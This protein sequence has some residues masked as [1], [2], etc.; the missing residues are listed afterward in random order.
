MQHVHRPKFTHVRFPEL[1][2]SAWKSSRNTLAL[3]RVYKSL[4]IENDPY[5]LSLR[6]ALERPQ[7]DDATRNRTSQRLSKALDKKDTFVHKG[8]R[9]FLRCAKD[10]CRDLG[11]WAADWYI[12]SVVHRALKGDAEIIHQ[13]F[14]DRKEPEK[15]Y[16]IEVLK[17]IEATSPDPQ[18]VSENCS[19]KANVYIECLLKE[20]SYWKEREQEFSGLTFITRRDGALALST[21]IN[22]HPQTRA[23]FVVGTLLGG[24]EGSK[25]CSLLD[26]T[27]T[28]LRETQSEVLSDFRVGERNLVIST[29]VAEEGID[30]QACCS[31]IRWDPPANMV[32]WAQSR[33]RAR[34]QSSSLILMAEE[35]GISEDLV[36]KWETIERQMVESYNNEERLR[37]SQLRQMDDDGIEDDE[38]DEFALTQ[39]G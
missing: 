17:K 14:V 28:L 35:G 3:E 30:I 18:S 12:A 26:I 34:R 29:A 31:V 23:E 19:A 15:A 11:T 21:L 6:K 13:L 32:S 8:M 9:D 7:R 2:D 5:V 33:G 22:L 27:H 10:L 37:K 1:S 4:N 20:K 16:L 24:S 36:R 25:H 39:T 38:Y